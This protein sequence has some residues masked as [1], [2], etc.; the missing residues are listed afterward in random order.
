MTVRSGFSMLI[1]VFALPACGTANKGARPLPGDTGGGG[2]TTLPPIV[3]GQHGLPVPPG[4]AVA[5][6]AGTAGNLAVLSW[7]GFKAA[8][9]W[10]FDDGQPS[11]IAHYAE[12]QATG[13][14][15]TFY[16]TTANAGLADFDATWAQAVRDGHEIGNHTVHHCHYDGTSLSGC[17][18]GS[19]AATTT[20]EDEIDQCTT[21]IASNYGQVGVWTMAA[22][23]GD[24]AYGKPAA[25]RFLANR[26]A[27]TGLIAPDG[28]TDRFNLP[29]YMAVDNDT[30][31][32]FGSQTDIARA[33]GKW[34]IFLIHT[35]TPTSDNW[36]APVDIADVTGG[37]T[38]GRSQG[39]V[40]MGTVADVAA[41]WVGQ[42]LL[43]AAAPTV[44]GGETTWAWT[45]PAGFPPGK[46]LRV[47]VDGGTL[48]QAGAPLPWDEHGYY[49]VALDAG[50][51]TLVP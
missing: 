43:A 10:T 3:M 45:L 12:L 13:V 33:G 40:W 1:L 15:M 9:S 48:A 22:P 38:Y 36:Y 8:V 35:I 20:V 17:T 34:L 11:H 26:G 28:N 49:E 44:T 42:Q 29:C 32:R 31:A 19:L 24:S 7:A 51:L 30:A 41:Y 21:H 46:Y 6:P 23:F 2:A 37:M 27:Y 50:A 18:S 14:P 5:K 16:V 47:K 39:D 4:G 25:A